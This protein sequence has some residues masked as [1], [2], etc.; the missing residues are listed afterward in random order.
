LYLDG[1]EP[2]QYPP[3]QGASGLKDTAIRELLNGLDQP[4]GHFCVITTRYR[5]EDLAPGQYVKEIEL[6]ELSPAAAE[7]LLRD[8][9]VWEERKGQLL[10]AAKKWAA[11]R[12]LSICWALTCSNTAPG[13]SEVA[14]QSAV[15]IR[16]VL[17]RTS[18]NECFGPTRINS[19]LLSCNCSAF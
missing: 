18:Q 3:K 14:I 6:Q 5:I 2:L 4:G 12:F 16:A 15:F 10:T 9:K 7:K 13:I 1:L 17:V 11:M 8:H 19:T